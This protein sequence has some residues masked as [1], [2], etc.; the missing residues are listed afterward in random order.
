MLATS[1]M[2]LPWTM[3][4]TLRIAADWTAAGLTDRRSFLAVTGASLARAVWAYL[5]REIPAQRRAVAGLDGDGALITQIEQSIPLLQ[6]LDDARGGAANLGYV[7]AQ[8]RAVS[9]VLAEGGHSDSMTRRLM[10]ALADL[11]QLAGWM[12]H[13][14]EK[15][16]L[17]QRYLFTA[18]RAAHDTGYRDMAGHILADLSVQA[19]AL[20]QPDDAVVLGEAAARAAALSTGSVRASV[21]S[22]LAH[23]YAGAGRVADFDRARRDALHLLADRDPARDPAWMY[24]LT[25]EHLDCQAGYSLVLMGRRTRQKGD[26]SAANRQLSVGRQLLLEGAHDR[27]PDDPSQRRALYEGAWLALGYAARGQNA[28][29]CAAGRAAVA[30]LDRVRS[31]RSIRL[32]GRL[33][34]DLSRRTRNKDVA[35]FL[36]DLR[37]AL[38]RAA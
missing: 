8:V 18:L 23:A 1:G 7:G 25:P 9:L 6:Q 17:A 3:D 11:A 16:G 33:A 35:E 15:E 19:T 13:D 5:A 36:P 21:T 14:A 29:A 38:G 20:G 2:E 26:A 28:E 37:S 27:P 31:P 12:A 34:E 30:R 22:R 32:L 4:S 24:Y 10:V